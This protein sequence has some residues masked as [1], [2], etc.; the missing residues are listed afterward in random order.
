MCSAG[1][2]EHMVL[3]LIAVASPHCCNAGTV[4]QA[5]LMALTDVIFVAMQ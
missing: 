5:T 2:A 1:R 3:A 4:T